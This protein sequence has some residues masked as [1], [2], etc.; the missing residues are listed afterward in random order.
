VIR[1]LVKT[2]RMRN[3][4]WALR[5]GSADLVNTAIVNAQENALVV[6][7]A[8]SR[9]T[10]AKSLVFETFAGHEQTDPTFG[11]S[12]IGVLAAAGATFSMKDSAIVYSRAVGLMVVEDAQAQVSGSIIDATRFGPEG[13]Q[14]SGIAAVVA[15]VVVE[16]SLVRSSQDAALVFVGGEGIVK[17][18][19]F[20]NNPVGVHISET[21]IVEATEDPQS[22][23]KNQL[24]F[25]QNVFEGT[26]TPVREAP[27]EPPADP[28]PL[29]N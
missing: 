12:G 14:A 25:F 18:T 3:G 1:G 6:S 27:Y 24:I 26:E 28:T 5:G 2:D 19:H 4:I 13:G 10:L 22:S 20:T 29:G 15:R 11:A 21:T 7:H 9:M 16:D 23:A 8:G 17:R